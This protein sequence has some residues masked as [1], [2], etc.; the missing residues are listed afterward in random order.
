MVKI[1]SV[2]RE[3]TTAGKTIAKTA[4]KNAANKSARAAL[5]QA[6]KSAQEAVKT[7]KG[8][9]ERAHDP[10]DAIPKELTPLAV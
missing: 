2:P 7:N 9:A 8:S 3:P 6:G 10:A 5:L 4:A 1:F